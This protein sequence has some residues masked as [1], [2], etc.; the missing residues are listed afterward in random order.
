MDF[1]G[2]MFMHKKKMAFSFI[3]VFV[4]MALVV[5]MFMERNAFSFG[6]ASAGKIDTSDATKINPLSDERQVSG[7]KL[8]LKTKELEVHMVPSTWEFKM[9]VPGKPFQTISQAQAAVNI[10]HVRKGS[11]SASWEV[12]AKGLKILVQVVKKSVKVKVE[13]NKETAVT[14]PVLGKKGRIRP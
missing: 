12:P 11:R 6:K 2:R 13:A 1:A 7:S 3:G 4:A 14:W 8:V 5:C 9:R 10:Q